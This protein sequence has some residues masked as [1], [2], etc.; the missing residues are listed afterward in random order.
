MKM[1]IQVDIIVPRIL[2]TITITRNIKKEFSQ[3]ISWALLK[4]LI[5][6]HA[7]QKTVPVNLS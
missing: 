7:S 1:E 2:P 4:C 6:R 5:A 3:T